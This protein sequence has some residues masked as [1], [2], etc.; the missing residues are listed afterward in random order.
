MELRKAAKIIPNFRATAHLAKT[1]VK[2][3]R[4]TIT[5]GGEITAVATLSKINNHSE[6]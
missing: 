2:I 1:T 4:I 6:E 3:L 5:I